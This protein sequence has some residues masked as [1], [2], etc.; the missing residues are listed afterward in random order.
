MTFLWTPVREGFSEAART[1]RGLLQV[2]PS[3]NAKPRSRLRRKRQYTIGRLWE[4]RT[5]P[6]VTLLYLG[7]VRLRACSLPRPRLPGEGREATDRCLPVEPESA[8]AHFSQSERHHRSRPCWPEGADEP[9]TKDPVPIQ[10]PTCP[11]DP[12]ASRSGG[13]LPQVGGAPCV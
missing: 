5:D 11:R 12:T 6:D 7:R 9:M 13:M 4:A 3:A 1:V 8:D 2:G 10:L